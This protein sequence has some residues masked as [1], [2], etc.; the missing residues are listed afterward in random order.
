MVG[1]VLRS[2][3][4]QGAGPGVR[5]STN[6]HREGVG[7]IEV[8]LEKGAGLAVDFRTEENQRILKDKLP[9]N[10]HNLRNKFR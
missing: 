8:D 2:R 1:A 6:L 5:I 7:P 4:L 3:P 10:I 9:L